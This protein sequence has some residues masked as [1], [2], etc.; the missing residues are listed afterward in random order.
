MGHGTVLGKP[1]FLLLCFASIC[2]SGVQGLAV[3]TGLMALQ[4]VAASWRTDLVST[5][6]P[7]YQRFLNCPPGYDG[8]ICQC[9]YTPGVLLDAGRL[10]TYN[11]LKQLPSVIL[12]TV[13]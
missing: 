1:V 11:R 5:R 9:C 3:P 8:R 6:Y 13:Q 4:A 12:V 2:D 10:H 7:M